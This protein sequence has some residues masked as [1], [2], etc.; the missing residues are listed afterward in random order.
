[1]CLWTVNYGLLLTVQI[2]DTAGTTEA[3][4]EL[5][6]LGGKVPGGS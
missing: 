2:L 6:A 3:S 5:Q 4:A 1:M